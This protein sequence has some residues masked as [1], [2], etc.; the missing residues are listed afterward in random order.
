[1]SLKKQF[2][3]LLDG[4]HLVGLIVQAKIPFTV[5]RID[6]GKL[7]IVYPGYNLAVIRYKS[8]SECGPAPRFFCVLVCPTEAHIPSTVEEASKIPLT[9]CPAYFMYSRTNAVEV[10]YRLHYDKI[11]KL[12]SDGGREKLAREAI[13]ELFNTM[14]TINS[15]ALSTGDE[16]MAKLITEVCMTYIDR[17]REVLD[18]HNT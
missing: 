16:K 9:V 11:K 18:A 17:Y 12:L 2:D 14:F 6:N 8:F 7:R 4:K 1:M 15:R 3:E 10:L 5:T 13:D